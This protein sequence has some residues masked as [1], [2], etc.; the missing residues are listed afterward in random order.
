MELL[1]HKLQ[2]NIF[3]NQQSLQLFILFLFMIQLFLKFGDSLFK[4]QIEWFQWGYFLVKILQLLMI[5]FFDLFFF[6][7]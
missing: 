7:F 6:S 4:L 2:L 5:F 1:C 3:F